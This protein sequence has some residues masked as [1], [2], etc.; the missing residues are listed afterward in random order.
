M[1]GLLVGPS[2]GLGV[3]PRS[4][5]DISSLLFA[6]IAWLFGLL[7][8]LVVV[9][10]NGGLLDVGPVERERDAALGRNVVSN[11]DVVAA[12]GNGAKANLLSFRVAA[13]G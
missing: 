7:H 2:Q 10:V 8:V 4:R 3:E 12:N 6:E 9:Q 5:Q 11:H 1:Q 13:A